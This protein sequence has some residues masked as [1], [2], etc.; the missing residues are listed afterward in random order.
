MATSF[1]VLYTLIK[2]LTQIPNLNAFFRGFKDIQT[3]ISHYSSVTVQWFTSLAQ[4][5]MSQAESRELLK[6][7]FFVIMPKYLF[8]FNGFRMN[9]V[10]LIKKNYSIN[11]ILGFENSPILPTR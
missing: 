11:D 3:F 7:G 6:R 1:S 5:V 4:A 8:E 10:N 9:L 2:C